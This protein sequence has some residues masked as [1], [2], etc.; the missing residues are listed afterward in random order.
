MNLGT[1]SVGLDSGNTRVIFR[2]EAFENDGRSEALYCTVQT[3]PCLRHFSRRLQ[4]LRAENFTFV[5]LE[6]RPRSLESVNPSRVHKFCRVTVAPCRLI[7]AG[8]SQQAGET[9]RNVSLPIA[10]DLGLSFRNTHLQ[11][12]F[13]THEKGFEELLSTYGGFLRKARSWGLKCTWT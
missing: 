7:S 5:F 11:F 4:K 1:D 13:R 3:L 9:T 8:D 12:C 6:E 2:L 10:A